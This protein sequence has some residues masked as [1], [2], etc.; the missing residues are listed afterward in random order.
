MQ[1][2]FSGWNAG[3]DNFLQREL[4]R[5]GGYR[6]CSFAYASHAHTYL[7]L[8][9]EAGI[10]AKVM[11]DSGAFT[12]WTSGKPVQLKELIYYSKK[13]LSQYGSRHD[14]IFISLDVIPGAK[15][16]TP[17]EAELKRAMEESY[18]NY[19]VYQQEIGSKHKVLP[20]YHSGEATS[21]RDRFLEHTDHI[22]L[23]MN[24]DMA[25]KHRVEWATR[26]QI[27]GVK[28]HGLA[29]TGV[30]MIKYVDWYSV[31]SAGWIMSAA[32]GQI[33]WPLENGRISSISI[34]STSPNLK[35][36]NAHAKT[37]SMDNELRDII[38]S[39]GFNLLELSEN[40]V[41]RMRWNMN[42]WLTHNWVRKQLVQEGLFND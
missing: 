5:L 24:Q 12:A 2:Y 41:T 22:C 14:F 1:L 16:R 42:V 37:I 25:E 27:S 28:L 15:G 35:R 9:E 36:K 13:L 26:N 38:E 3:E 6:L 23:S 29:A 40:P 39:R 34:S 11:I 7:E 4:I 30:Q 19:I 18:D 8:A 20:V 21:F 10:R 17:T 31:D 33:M 32:M